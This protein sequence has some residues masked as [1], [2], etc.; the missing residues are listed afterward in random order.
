MIGL[1]WVIP[2]RYLWL[3]LKTGPVGFLTFLG[4]APSRRSSSVCSVAPPLIGEVG[5][6]SV[7]MVS[8]SPVGISSAPIEGSFARSTALGYHIYPGWFR[9]EGG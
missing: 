2:V 6:H 8:K 9:E 7:H 5:Y 1:A 3:F 4:I